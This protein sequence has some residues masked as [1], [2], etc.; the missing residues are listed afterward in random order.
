MYRI[1]YYSPTGNTLHLAKQIASYFGQTEA[2]LI[3]I[4][5]AKPE[6]PKTGSHLI[7]MSAINGFNLPQR[8]ID[9]ARRLDSDTCQTVS[10]VAVGCNDI[11]INDAATLQVSRILEKKGIGIQVNEVLAMPLTFIMSFPEEAGKSVISKSEKALGQLVEKIQKGEVAQKLIPT[12]AKV[13]SRM[14]RLEKP[15][16]RMFGLELHASKKC[17]SCG[18]CWREC[19]AGNI[20]KTANGKPKFGFKCTMCMKCIYECPEKAIGPYVSRFIPIKGGYRLADYLTDSPV[21]EGSEADNHGLRG[22]DDE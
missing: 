2:D 9:Y 12:K 3:N 6:L 8:V 10:I 21:A 5:T 15:A 18:K 16:A 13:I 1:A 4:G 11:W 17:T 19:P 14:G 7:L 22:N 20:K